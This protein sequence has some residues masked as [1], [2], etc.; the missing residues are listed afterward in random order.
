[1]GRHFLAR[2]GLIDAAEALR[3]T[4]TFWR[5]WAS[6]AQPSGQGRKRGSAR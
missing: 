4:E 6:L 1:M 5:G 2:P 3:E